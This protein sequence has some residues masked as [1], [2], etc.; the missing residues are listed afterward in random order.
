[1]EKCWS[2]NFGGWLAV[3]ILFLLLFFPFSFL[4]AVSTILSSLT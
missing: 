1:M 3:G 2:G 4:F